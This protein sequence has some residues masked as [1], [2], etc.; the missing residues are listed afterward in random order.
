MN[1][2]VIEKPRSKA[3]FW[4]AVTLAVLVLLAAIALISVQMLNEYTLEMSLCG[5]SEI[6]LSYGEKYNDPGIDIAFYG[7]ILQKDGVIPHDTQYS[8]NSN[9]DTGKIGT[10]EV[11]YTATFRKWT[12]TQTRIVHIVD[13]VAPVITLNTIEGHYTI[14]GEAYTEEGFTAIDEYDGDITD[15]VTAVEQDGV[16]TYTVADSSGNQA[17]VERKIYYFDPTPPELKL[18]GNGIVYLNY[19]VSY[20]E[21]GYSATDNLEGDITDKVTV[22]GSVDCYSPGTY[23]ITYQ[24]SDSFGNAVTATRT[25]IVRSK[26]YTPPQQE[27]VTPEGRVIYLTFDDG[28]GAYT[29]ALLA[30]LA[31]YNVK[32]TFFVVNNGRYSDLKKIAAAGHSIGIHT[33][34]HDYAKVYAS[35]EAFFAEVYALQ[36]IIYQQTGI[37]TTLLRFPGGSSN[38]VSKFNPGIMSRLT[39]AVQEAGFQYFDWNVDSYDAGGAKTAQEVYEKVVQGCSGKRTSIVLQHDIKGFSVDAVEKIIIWGLENGYRF[40]PLDPTSPGAHHGVNN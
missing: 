15:R 32:V 25:V 19:G 21:S 10:Y 13:E 35:E 33:M 16:V 11:V 18:L 29:D 3:L 5:D 38:T 40:L 39:V 20:K 23:T 36:N 24:V 6:T 14:P 30:V 26:P 1:E 31:K 17:V 12:A 37:T 22:S 4:S 2:Q 7:T 8:C 28:P 34:T 9:V 27:T